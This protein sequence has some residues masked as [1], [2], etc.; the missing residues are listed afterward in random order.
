[1]RRWWEGARTSGDPGGLE[2]KRRWL[3]T[4]H[5]V[6][7]A[8]AA[9]AAGVV[10]YLWTSGAAPTLVVVGVLFVATFAVRLVPMFVN[11]TTIRVWDERVEV[12]TVLCPRS[13]FAIAP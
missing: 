10:A 6:L 2:I 7:L 12:T 9:C 5:F 11:T 13:C 4:K 3:R 8:V 1:M